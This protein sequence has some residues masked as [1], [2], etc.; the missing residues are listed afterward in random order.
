[1]AGAAAIGSLDSKCPGLAGCPK[2][3][4]PQVAAQ[5][6][7]RS[8]LR[9]EHVGRAFW[10]RHRGVDAPSARRLLGGAD[11]ILDRPVSGA[12]GG[13]LQPRRAV[14][15]RPPPVH[16]RRTRLRRPTVHARER[17]AHVERGVRQRPRR[18]TG[19]RRARGNGGE[20]ARASHASRS[21][22]ASHLGHRVNRA[23]TARP[24]RQRERDG[25]RRRSRLWRVE[26]R[27]H[28]GRLSRRRRSLRARGQRN[29]SRDGRLTRN[30]REH[31]RRLPGLVCQSPQQGE[32]LSSCKG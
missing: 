23:Q 6:E 5:G 22:H 32:P 21:S 28:C 30:G 7:R 14:G 29:A 15:G 2:R 13:L 25:R 26:G 17:H 16:M 20:D 4:P 11:G 9:A 31:P 18:W 27:G 19:R 1:M 10:S 8:H 3:V 24:E 12:T